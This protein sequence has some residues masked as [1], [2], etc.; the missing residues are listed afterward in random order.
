MKVGIVSESEWLTVTIS[1]GTTPVLPTVTRGNADADGCLTAL[2]F[3]ESEQAH[4]PLHIR[5]GIALRR[6]RIGELLG[7]DLGADENDGGVEVL[8]NFENAG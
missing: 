3:A 4:H 6:Q 1:D 5:C 7:F 2:V 8:F